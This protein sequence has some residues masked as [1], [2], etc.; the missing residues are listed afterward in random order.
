MKC[1]LCKFI[2]KSKSEIENHYINFHNVDKENVYFKK[3]LTKKDDVFSGERCSKCNEFIPTAEYKKSH[4]FLKHYKDGKELMSEEKPISIVEIGNNI[5]KYEIN[6]REHSSF[7]DFF[8]SNKVVDDFL[9]NVRG[10]IRRSNEYFLIRC[11]FSIENFQPVLDSYS[12]PLKDTR[13]WST[14]PIET[15]S[16]NDFVY[17]NVR[18]SILKRVINNGLTGSSWRFNRFVYINVKTF[19]VNETILKT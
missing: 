13:Y 4:N 7:Y 11:G 2:S 1:L 5:K 17:F 12:E 3:L 10:K 9:S 6:Y 15:K 8:N 16:F 18:E 19:T 14:D